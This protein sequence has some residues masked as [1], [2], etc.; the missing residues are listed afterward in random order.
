VAHKVYTN[1]SDHLIFLVNVKT[2]VCMGPYCEH[3]RF[4]IQPLQTFLYF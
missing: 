1:F 3:W 2:T 4:F